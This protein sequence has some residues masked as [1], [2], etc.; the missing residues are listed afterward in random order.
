MGSWSTGRSAPDIVSGSWATG[1]SA[2][3][4]VG[5]RGR[6]A[7]DIVGMRG[8]NAPDIVGAA[9]RGT[10]TVPPPRQIVQ[11]ARVARGKARVAAQAAR[12]AA[13][14]GDAAGAR[15]AAVEARTHA[16]T[17]RRQA[18]R[19]TRTHGVGAIAPADSRDARLDE[20]EAAV[21]LAYRAGETARVALLKDKY[22][23]VAA[24]IASNEAT[25][26]EADA[27]AA[28]QATREVQAPS[29]DDEDSY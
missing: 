3:D 7:P 4:I 13:T 1:R 15:R 29:E 26:A 19:L 17:A 24:A 16:T 6:N 5:M 10:T 27:N 22:D 20:I 2:P 11:H 23:Q 14:R 9:R 28:E 25:E 8:R 12:Q 21:A 18:D